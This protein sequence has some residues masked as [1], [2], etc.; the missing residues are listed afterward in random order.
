M[1]AQLILENGIRF[2]G[3]MF[4]YYNDIAGEVVF[5]T[6][7]G[8]YQES[9]TD[10]S[11]AGQIVTMTFPLVGNYGINLEDNE[12]DHAWLKALI[13]REKCDTPSNFR[14][15][16]NLNDFLKEEKVVGLEGIDTRALTRVLRDNGTMKGVIM[17]GEPTDESVK[18]LMN[19]PDSQNYIMQTTT[20]TAYTLNENGKTHVAVIDLGTKKSILER[21]AMRDCKLTVFPADTKPEDIEAVNPDTV[22]VSSGAGT[23]DDAAEIVKTV[24]ALIGKYP[25]GGICMGH[26]VIGLALGCKAKKMKFGHHGENHPVKDTQTGKIYISSQGHDY[27]LCDLPDDVEQ[28]FVNVNDGTCEGIKHKTLP[29][30]SFQFHPEAAPGP[31]DSAALFDRFFKEVK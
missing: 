23:P 7:M 2:T 22:F 3:E 18:S 4:G 30:M 25:I 31:L 13:V 12:S 29:V 14:N 15:E 20:K 11:L 21:I 10:P 27:T 17:R 1:K 19:A 6:G 28:T 8:G 9:L 16:M 24:K 26:I 5:S